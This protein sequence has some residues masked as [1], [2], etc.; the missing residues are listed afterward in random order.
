M[1]KT[2]S[3][4]AWV[5]RGAAVILALA[6]AATMSLAALAAGGLEEYRLPRP[7]GESR[8]QPGL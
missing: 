2:R 3:R 7:D 8:R 4:A 5:R 6:L 1:K